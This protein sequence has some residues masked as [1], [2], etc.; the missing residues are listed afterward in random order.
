MVKRFSG[1]DF[2]EQRFKSLQKSP[3]NGPDANN[4]SSIAEEKLDTGS[5]TDPIPVITQTIWPQTTSPTHQILS[6]QPIAI[7]QVSAVHHVRNSLSISPSPAHSSQSASIFYPHSYDDKEEFLTVVKRN[8][9]HDKKESLNPPSSEQKRSQSD[10]VYRLPI[11][12][13]PVLKLKTTNLS[14]L[15]RRNRR[16]PTQSGAVA[17]TEHSSKHPKH[18]HDADPSKECSECPECLTNQMDRAFDDLTHVLQDS[19]RTVSEN[20]VNQTTPKLVNTSA[21]KMPK[22]LRPRAV[23]Q[24]LEKA[25]QWADSREYDSSSVSSA[26]SPMSPVMPTKALLDDG[27]HK[28]DV[29][30]PEVEVAPMGYNLVHDLGDFLSWEARN[31]CLYEYRT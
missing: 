9:S 1:L 14:I 15:G 19:R 6:S 5:T 17:S 28:K 3:N 2:W 26:S 24:E 18:R 10:P 21:I 16:R 11:S 20:M 30:A 29:V 13:R 25:R 23:S 4:D 12:R 22:P 27:D 7:K 31:V 8:N